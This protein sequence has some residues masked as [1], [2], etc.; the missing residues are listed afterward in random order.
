MIRISLTAAEQEHL[1]LRARSADA[2]T[3]DRL[4]M[5]RLADAGWSI[6]RI[7]GYLGFHEQTVRRQVKAFLAGGFDALPDRPRSG[8]PP[9][10][11]EADLQAVDALLDAGERTWTL[12]QLVAWLAAERQVHIHPEHL[13]RLLRRRRF[14]WK[15]TVSSV[16]HQRRDPAAYA[17][18]V[19]DLERLKK[20]WQPA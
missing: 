13:R 14:A 20:K 4:E 11:T 19:A 16:A 3:R 9:Q 10:I 1:R 2:R 8:R 5:I 17:A 15:R 18:K 7:A 6:P 12:R